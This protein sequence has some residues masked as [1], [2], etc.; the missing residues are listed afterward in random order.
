M[1]E[2]ES[3]DILSPIN[4]V[5]WALTALTITRMV[6][7]AWLESTSIFSAAYREARTQNNERVAWRR[8]GDRSAESTPSAPVQHPTK[9]VEPPKQALDPT[10]I[11][12]ITKPPR[13]QGGF[14][15]NV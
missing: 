4:N 1:I 6:C 3:V 9:I 7:R 5:L 13:P 8:D 11:T 2:V 14:G 10:T 12:A 15:S